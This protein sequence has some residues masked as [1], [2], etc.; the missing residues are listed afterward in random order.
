MES[1]E[2]E[3]EMGEAGLDNVVDEKQWN[4]DEDT[5]DKS[6]EEKFEDSGMQGDTIQGESHTRDEEEDLPEREEGVDSNKNKTIESEKD[7]NEATNDSSKERP[8]RTDLQ[9]RGEEESPTNANEDN[10]TDANDKN[11]ADSLAPEGFDFPEQM[12]IDD[13]GEDDED[14]MSISSALDQVI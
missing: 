13:N 2:L 4:K 7:V 1:E 5:L 9:E 12:E 8:Q 3:R 11:D 6:S 14:G 10:E